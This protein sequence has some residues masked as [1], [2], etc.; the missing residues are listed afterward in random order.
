MFGLIPCS[1]CSLLFITRANSIHFSFGKLC[2]PF[3]KGRE[4]QLKKALFHTDTIVIR[5]PGIFPHVRKLQ[6]SLINRC[7]W[8]FIS[9]VG[10]NLKPNKLIYIYSF[11][12][13]CLAKRLK[14]AEFYFPLPNFITHHVHKYNKADIPLSEWFTYT[15]GYHR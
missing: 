13:L 7:P 6:S 11:L 14:L 10:F 15:E 1:A 12:Y 4:I 9:V 2:P 5:L 8:S 3:W